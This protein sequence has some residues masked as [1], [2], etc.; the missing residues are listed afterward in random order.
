MEEKTKLYVATNVEKREGEDP[1]FFVLGVFDS[2][3]KAK[4]CIEEAVEQD[5]DY[6][7]EDD[8]EKWS[9]VEANDK[10][11]SFSFVYDEWTY[12]EYSIIENIL[13]V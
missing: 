8:L 9:R 6:L 12:F 7:D 3:E 2:P 13:N 4:A 5:T 1:E 11:G 10:F